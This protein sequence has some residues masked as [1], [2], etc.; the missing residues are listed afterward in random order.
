MRALVLAFLALALCAP[1]PAAS[2][3]DPLTQTIKDS[4][5]KLQAFSAGFTQTLS[6]K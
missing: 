2:A 3:A 1:A 5:E 6:N 4:Y